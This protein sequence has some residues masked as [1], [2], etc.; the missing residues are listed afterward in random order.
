MPALRSAAIA[1]LVVAASTAATATAQAP[2]PTLQFAKACYSEPESM[3]FSGA[4]YTPLGEV[5]LLFGTAETFRG[6]Y[7]TRADATGAIEDSVRTTES[8]FLRE[9]E[10]REEIFVTANDRTRVDANQQPVE[11]QVG[12]SSLTFT[13]WLG[14][15]PGRYVPGRRVRVEA[16]G[17]SFAA[18]R[19]LYVLFRKGTRTVA[20]VRAG[21]LRGECGDLDRRIR[22]PRRLKAGRYT[23][24]FS[25]LRRRPS[26]LH[27]WRRGRVTAA[28]GA[29]GGAA[30]AAAPGGRAMARD[31]A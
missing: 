15:S 12:R 9:Q 23:I 16:W 4:N 14:R 25:T 13:R 10:Q 20:S 1:A 3:A 7:T 29:A 24:M 31:G 2:Q 21:R 27:S 19:T 30:S 17:W 8:N 11:S 6:S 18:G 5:Q 22:V 26:D 28:G